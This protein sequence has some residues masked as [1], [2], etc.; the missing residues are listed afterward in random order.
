MHFSGDFGTEPISY[1]NTFWFKMNTTGLIQDLA[2][3]TPFLYNESIF[4]NQK[5]CLFF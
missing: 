5:A 3:N 4:N 2:R 1:R